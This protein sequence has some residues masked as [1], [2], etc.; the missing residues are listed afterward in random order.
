[1]IQDL[2]QIECRRG[3]LEEDMKPE[4]LPFKIWR[5]VRPK[6]VRADRDLDG[7]HGGGW[8]PP[9]GGPRCRRVT[10]SRLCPPAGMGPD[11]IPQYPMAASACPEP[12]GSRCGHRY[13]RRRHRHQLRHLRR[14]S[15]RCVGPERD[16]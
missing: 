3:M 9:G 8:E 12:G 10:A 7:R 6:P 16:S 2:E 5:G 15:G 11:G 14:A 1:M 13:A 4:N